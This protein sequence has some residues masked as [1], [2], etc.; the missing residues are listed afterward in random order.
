MSS[1]RMNLLFMKFEQY[2]IAVVLFIILVNPLLC[3]LYRL[4]FI[5]GI[6]V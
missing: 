5:I 6:Y 1:E 2:V 4:N 3:L